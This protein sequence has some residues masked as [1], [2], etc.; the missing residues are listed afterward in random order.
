MNRLSRIFW[1]LFSKFDARQFEILD[2]AR[3]G[4]ITAKNAASEIRLA[5]RDFLAE[6]DPRRML[7]FKILFD[8]YATAFDNGTMSHNDVAFEM[9]VS[10]R[11]LFAEKDPARVNAFSEMMHFWHHAHQDGKIDAKDAAR[12]VF[13]SA[14][15][16]LP[17]GLAKP[18]A[19]HFF[20]VDDS[21]A[22][23]EA[24]LRVQ[25]SMLNMLEQ[26]LSGNRATTPAQSPD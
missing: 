4:E 19:G 8:L 20:K 3:K 25:I 13:L 14:L 22:L 26:N 12:L 11:D 1:G 2:Q 6:N 7:A 18:H 23:H 15:V 10:A 16:V 17:E 21:D 9:R 5:A 24:V